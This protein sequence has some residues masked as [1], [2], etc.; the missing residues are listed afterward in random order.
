VVLAVS[1]NVIWFVG[2]TV[3]GVG[4]GFALD[5]LGVNTWARRASRST[6]W[7]LVVATSLIALV[8]GIAYVIWPTD[9][10][11]WLT[12]VAAVPAT[13]LLLAWSEDD[14]GKGTNG[15]ADSGPWVPP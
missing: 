2:L 3:G 7:L 10:A 8:G 11:W 15:F 1:A 13:L 6:R 14:E 12:G 5:Y 4:V 9:T